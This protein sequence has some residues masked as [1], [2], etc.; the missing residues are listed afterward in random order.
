MGC[1]FG[2]VVTGCLLMTDGSGESGRGT[3]PLGGSA[4]AEAGQR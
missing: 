2:L 4:R 3:R 1:T